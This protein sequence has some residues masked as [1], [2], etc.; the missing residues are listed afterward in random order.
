MNKK[1]IELIEN[2]KTYVIDKSI[3]FEEISRPPQQAA[4]EQGCVVEIRDKDDIMIWRRGD[5]IE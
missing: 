3:K 4:L 1:L 5:P 2:G